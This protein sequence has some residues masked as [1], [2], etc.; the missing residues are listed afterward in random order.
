MKKKNILVKVTAMVMSFG[1]G[2]SMG[3]IWGVIA[4]CGVVPNGFGF[5][6]LEVLLFHGMTDM[7]FTTYGQNI[8]EDKVT[9]E[10]IY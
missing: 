3:I 9:Y 1:I 10:R 6:W 7:D 8:E 2:I 5:F 4:A